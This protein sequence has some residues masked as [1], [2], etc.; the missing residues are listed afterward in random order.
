MVKTT[1][2]DTIDYHDARL[3]ALEAGHRLLGS[4]VDRMEK[5]VM[6]MQLDV[7]RITRLVESSD[8]KLDKL[9]TLAGVKTT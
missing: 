7:T 9:L 3:T 4:K 1:L 8:G 2:R 5:L 6:S